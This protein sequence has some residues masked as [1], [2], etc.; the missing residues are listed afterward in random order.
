[1]TQVTN[2]LNQV[3]KDADLG[4][5]LTQSYWEP[6]ELKVAYELT[7]HLSSQDL[8]Q[9]LASENFP[10]F[11]LKAVSVDPRNVVMRYSK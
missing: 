8:T 9:K 6:S 4:L 3:I 1:M 2:S 5:K 11:R 7:T 10:N